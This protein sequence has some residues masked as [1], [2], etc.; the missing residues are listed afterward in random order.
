[1]YYC[2]GVFTLKFMVF[3]SKVRL[4]VKLILHIN[5]S[6]RKAERRD[7]RWRS[8]MKTDAMPLHLPAVEHLKCSNLN[9]VLVELRLLFKRAVISHAVSFSGVI[10]PRRETF[11]DLR[12]LFILPCFDFLCQLTLAFA[13]PT[14]HVPGAAVLLR[15]NNSVFIN[16]P[17]R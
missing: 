5:L 1:M 17:K 8:N 9:V 10:T 13:A 11:S 3:L 15:M 16:E 12:I 2:R 7:L 4:S 6:K 14:I